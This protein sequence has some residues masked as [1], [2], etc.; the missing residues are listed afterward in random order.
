MRTTIKI[1]VLAVL[2]LCSCRLQDYTMPS[3][4]LMPAKKW[5]PTVS[6]NYYLQA[7]ALLM[8]RAERPNWRGSSV[9]ISFIR[10]K[11]LGEGLN[12]VAADKFA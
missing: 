4:K 5:G 1:I 2:P 9:V 8:A 12:S 11:N 10:H 7:W 3:F 6:W